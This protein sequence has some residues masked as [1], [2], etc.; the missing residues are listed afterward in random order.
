MKSLTKQLQAELKASASDEKY[1]VMQTHIIP[2]VAADSIIGVRVPDIRKIAAAHKSDDVSEF[3]DELPH[4]YLE[5][6]YLHSF[7]IASMRDFGECM[8]RTE[9]FLPHID[10]WAVCDSFAPKC[11]AK[12][13][14]ELLE[15]ISEWHGSPHTYTVRFA[16]GCLM[17]WYLD[18][19]FEP[20]FL[21]MAAAVRSE[22]YYVNMM[23]AWY[24]ATALAKQYE[25]ALP[26]ITEH[27]LDPWT[28]N[29]A[30][31][32]ACESFR[33]SD[34]HKAELKKFKV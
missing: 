23:T 25:S 7:F 19:D 3:L 24:F 9:E 32:K 1:R 33:V 11:F 27:R 16:T 2:T 31:Q 4:R 34:E 17:R 22:E 21:D 5:E 26:Y 10:N 20:R 12:H 14:A 29:K 30:I 28:H 8:R 13:K 6:N 15:K 18:A